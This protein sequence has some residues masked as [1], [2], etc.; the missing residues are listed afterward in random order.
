METEART[1]VEV[2]MIP[3]YFTFGQI[4][5]STHPKQKVRL[6]D[7]WVEVL[8]PENYPKLHRQVFIEQFADVYLPRPMQWS[9][10]YGPG[11]RFMKDL[12]PAGCLTRIILEKEEDLKS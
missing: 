10:E 12:F 6:A 4:H 9:F 1:N 5:T 7:Y 8:L 2:E 3:H 11:N